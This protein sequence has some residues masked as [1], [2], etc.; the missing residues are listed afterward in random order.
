MHF[1]LARLMPHP[2][3]DGRVVQFTTLVNVDEVLLFTRSFSLPEL[4]RRLLEPAVVHL[5]SAMA[6]RRRR[7]G[8]SRGTRGFVVGGAPPRSDMSFSGHVS[9]TGRIRILRRTRRASGRRS[10]L[11]LPRH[12]GEGVFCLSESSKGKG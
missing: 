9:I 1:I 7:R 5:F 10:V 12:D 11:I 6:A 2:E 8:G 4:P 3:G